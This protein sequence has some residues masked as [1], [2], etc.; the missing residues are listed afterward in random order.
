M[1]TKG[2]NAVAWFQGQSFNGASRDLDPVVSRSE[3]PGRKAAAVNE[4]QTYGCQEFLECEHC[5][6][7]TTESFTVPDC[8]PATG[9]HGVRVVCRECRDGNTNKCGACR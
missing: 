7:E 5:R 9:Y 2:I 3:A 1:K 4:E 8:D 6:A